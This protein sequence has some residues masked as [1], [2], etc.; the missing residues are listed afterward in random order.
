MT[1]TGATP[2]AL[3]YGTEAIIPAEV[4]SPSFHVTHYNSGLNDEGIK[5]HLDLLQER[6]DEVQVTWLAY[7]D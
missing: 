1:P 3:T 5:L 4:G 6:R 7:Q 2:F